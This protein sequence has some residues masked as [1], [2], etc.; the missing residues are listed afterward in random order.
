MQA[1]LRVNLRATLASSVQKTHR[2]FSS[3]DIGRLARACI[4]EAGRRMSLPG[5]PSQDFTQEHIQ[6]VPLTR[7]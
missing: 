5:E 1:I 4:A 3:S 2:K 7:L 6:Q